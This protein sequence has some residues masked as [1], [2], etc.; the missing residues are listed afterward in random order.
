MCLKTY[1]DLQALFGNDYQMPPVTMV[2]GDVV[3]Y[4]CPYIPTCPAKANCFVAEAPELLQDDIIL[5]VKCRL[6]GNQKIPV[7]V[8]NA[9]VKK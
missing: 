1:Q 6:C 7:Y 3:E 9:V 5:N 8:K 2:K 4:R